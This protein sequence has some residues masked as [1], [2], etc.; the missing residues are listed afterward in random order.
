MSTAREII[1]NIDSPSK[2]KELTEALMFGRLG[3]TL[4][5]EQ[6]GDTPDDESEMDAKNAAKAEVAEKTKDKIMESTLDI[7][8]LFSVGKLSEGYDVLTEA[9][10][11][12]LTQIAEG[13]MEDEEDDEMDGEEEEDDGEMDSEEDDDEKKDVMEA[14]II[15]KVNSR[16]EKRRRLKC[17]PG[18]K[19]ENGVCVPVSGA[20]KV[21]K[22][23]SAKKAARTKHAQGAGYALKVAKKSK[24]A[25][26][27]RKSFGLHEATDTRGAIGNVLNTM[28]FGGVKVPQATYSADKESWDL[29][30][31]MTPSE[32]KHFGQE[33][34]KINGKRFGGVEVLPYGQSMRVQV[35]LK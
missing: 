35:S 9:L 27:K 31:K 4:T 22:L 26:M 30:V 13:E 16:G 6:C 24:K 32:M 17:N 21:N 10:E 33:L 14:T 20:A 15:T 25:M 2:I 12:R 19:L 34:N 7:V 11:L 8:D 3:Q 28:G 5:V 1:E 18:Y 29:G 23:R